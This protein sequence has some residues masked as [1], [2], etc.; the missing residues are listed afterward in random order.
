VADSTVSV[1]DTASLAVIQ[2]FS[3]PE[4]DGRKA[5]PWGVAVDAKAGRLYVTATGQLPQPD[6]TLMTDGS[7]RLDVLDL[8]DG[9]LISSIVVG[10]GPW[11]VAVDTKTGAAFVGVTSTNEVVEVK[12]DQVVARVKVGDNPH[13]VII[14]PATNR[15]YVNN[16]KSNSVSVVDTDSLKVVA[17]VAV[18]QQPQGIALDTRHHLLYTANQAA[19]T[20]TVIAL[21]G[22]PA[23]ASP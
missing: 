18:G 1:I 19:G 10:A 11:N 15:L 17:S 21:T 8:A 9:H 7:D 12:G 3:L 5:W 2:T 16:A 13:S 22:G 20:I 4:P 23:T 6:G 14:D